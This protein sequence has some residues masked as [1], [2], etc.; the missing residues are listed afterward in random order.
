[1]TDLAILCDELLALIEAK[2][3]DAKQ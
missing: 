3:A 2:A 1:V